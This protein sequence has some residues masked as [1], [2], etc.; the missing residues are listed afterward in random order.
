MSVLIIGGD[1]IDTI[2]GILEQ[3]GDFSITHW[4]T[5]K[6]SSACRKDI[7]QNTDYILMLTDFINHNAM[8]KYRKEAKKKNI[9]LICTKRS[10]SAVYCEVCK[11]LN[12]NKCED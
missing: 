3:F 8:Y 12:I 10:A 4:D 5:R 2:K 11:F 1:K 7:P 6:K 9:P